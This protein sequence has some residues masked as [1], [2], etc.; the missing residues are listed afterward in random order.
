MK[1]LRLCV[2]VLFVLVLIVFILFRIQQMSADRTVPKITIDGEML[3]V[4]LDATE[5]ELLQGV[6]AYDEKDGDLTHKIIIESISRFSEPGVSVIKYAVCDN[7]NHASSAQ[8]KI[9]YSNYEPPKFTLS[10]SLI[11]GISQNI[12]IR[13]LLGAQ[14]L[15]DGDI[16]SKVIITANEYSSNVAGVF[17]IQAKVANSKGD[18]I[19]LQLPVYVEDLSL[20]APKIELNEYLVYLHA[21]D[22]YDTAANIVSARNAQGQNVL[23]DVQIDTNLDTASPGMYEVHYRVT[24]QFDRTGHEIL[25]VVVEE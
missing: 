13:N 20:S 8:R 5:E 1:I 17:Y 2:S 18:R 24:D 10:D 14:D 23:A 19:A 12:N 6:T 25:T 3:T 16:S 9:I 4:S 15:I 21:G 7:D 22:T 11:F